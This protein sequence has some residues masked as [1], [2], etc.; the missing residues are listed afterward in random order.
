[1]AGPSPVSDC[2]WTVAEA[3]ARLSELLRCAR[4]NGPQRIGTRAQCVVIA[5]EQWDALLRPRPP[6]GRWLL[7]NIPRD[8]TL[9]PP[10]RRDPPRPIPFVSEEVSSEDGE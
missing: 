8:T 10:G 5:A 6:I 3:K 1:M 2:V 9:D 4:D 7:K